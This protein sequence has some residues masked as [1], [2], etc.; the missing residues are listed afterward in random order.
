MADDTERRS[1]GGAV[2]V[3]LL[4]RVL[5][6]SA[7]ERD[8]STWRRSGSSFPSSHTDA[9]STVPARNILGSHHQQTADVSFGTRI[10]ARRLVL[11]P[12]RLCSEIVAC[13][14]GLTDFV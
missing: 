6:E 12:R 5:L 14:S 1:L 3:C 7:H 11:F 9:S 10:P 2:R 4:P 13:I 8:V